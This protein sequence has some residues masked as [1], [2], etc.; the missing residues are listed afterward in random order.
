MRE[1]LKQGIV[2][3]V[4]ENHPTLSIGVSTCLIYEDLDGRGS[5]CIEPPS[6]FLAEYLKARYI[7]NPSVTIIDPDA[8]ETCH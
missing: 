3:A 5:Y 2:E 8:M 1:T 7:N 6:S 4:G